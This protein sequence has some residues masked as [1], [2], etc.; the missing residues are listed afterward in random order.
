MRHIKAIFADGL[1]TQRLLEELNISETC[2]LRG[3]YYHLMHQV[4]PKE[5]NFGRECFMKIKTYLKCMLLSKI[6]NEWEMAHVSAKLKLEGYP[7]KLE[8]LREIYNRPSYYAGYYLT[9]IPGNL[10][11]HGTASSES[12]HSSIVRHFGESGAWSLVYQIKKLLERQRYFMSQDLLSDDKLFISNQNFESNFDGEIYKHD[13]K[14]KAAL[15]HYAYNNLWLVNLK[16]KD[17]LQ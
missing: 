3:D 4:F 2:V 17:K 8:I 9:N 6:S 10:N 11:I 16:R 7:R 5:H 14:A 12:N 15:S 13:I 1:I